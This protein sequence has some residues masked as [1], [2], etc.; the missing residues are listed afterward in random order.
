MG[1]FINDW[2]DPNRVLVLDIPAPFLAAFP[3]PA[4]PRLHRRRN[5]EPAGRQI[6]YI[7]EFPGHPDPYL[8]L[9]APVLAPIVALLSP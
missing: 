7:M 8:A 5:P 9:L 3:S 2:A 1:S 6:C 4:A